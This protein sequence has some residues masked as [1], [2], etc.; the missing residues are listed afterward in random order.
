MLEYQTALLLKRRCFEKLSI[1]NRRYD[2]LVALDLHLPN[3]ISKMSNSNNVMFC[4]KLEAL[5]QQ[6][7]VTKQQERTAKRK[8]DK[9]AA[10]EPAAKKAKKV[11][12]VPMYLC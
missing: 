7:K 12:K 6:N 4:F 2:P 9:E 8:K 1:E 10:S 3:G 5:K 11:R